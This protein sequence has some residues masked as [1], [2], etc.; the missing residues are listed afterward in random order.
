MYYD[1]I[2]ILIISSNLPTD[3]AE[4]RKVNETFDLFDVRISVSGDLVHWGFVCRIV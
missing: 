1:T 2:R 3:R 4:R